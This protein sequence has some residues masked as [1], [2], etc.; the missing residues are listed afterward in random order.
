MSL[1]DEPAP[2]NP[3]GAE[4]LPGI[5]LSAYP[6]ALRVAGALLVLLAAGNVLFLMVAF[7]LDQLDGDLRIPPMVATQRLLYFSLLPYAALMVMRLLTFSELRFEPGQLVLITRRAR[8]EIPF[9]SVKELRVWRVP[10]PFAGL[11]VRM[12]SG[13]TFRYGLEVPYPSLVIAL[14]GHFSSLS[15]DDASHPVTLYVEARAKLG[16]KPLSWWLKFG[17]A[18]LV[19]ALI[20]FRAHQYIAYGGPFGEYQTHGLAAYV[21][22]FLSYWTNTLMLVVLYTAAWRTFAEVVAFAVP[23]RWPGWARFARRSVEILCLLGFYVG[24]PL[25]ILARFFL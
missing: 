7:L 5:P 9:E 3:T 17:L 2:P 6:L 20:F 8:Y 22:T 12:K 21:R 10:L 18:P 14:A 25:I 23:W 11:S 24:V 1:P 4:P 16:P 13:R 19:V 15:T